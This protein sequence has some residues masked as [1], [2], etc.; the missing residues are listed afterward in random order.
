MNMMD[1]LVGGLPDDR[2]DPEREVGGHKVHE[3]EP[4]EH[5]ELLHYH[6]EGTA[7]SVPFRAINHPIN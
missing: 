7:F 6:L 3:A 1:P 4:R 5:P 2:P